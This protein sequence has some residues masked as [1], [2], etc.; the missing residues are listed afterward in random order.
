MPTA[1]LSSVDLKVLLKAI[2]LFVSLGHGDRSVHSSLKSGSKVEE[3]LTANLY[4]WLVPKLE[5]RRDS[6]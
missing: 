2:Y 3:D 5:L 1:L 4:Q 6:T